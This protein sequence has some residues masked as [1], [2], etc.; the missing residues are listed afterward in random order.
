MMYYDHWNYMHG[1][2]FG[3]GPF[4][5][6]ALALLVLLPFWQLFTKAGYSGWWCLVMLAPG[7]NLVALYVLAFSTW[8]SLRGTG[9]GSAGAPRGTA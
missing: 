5:G 1:L 6:L 4:G 3:F 9:S 7:F 8:P 2:G